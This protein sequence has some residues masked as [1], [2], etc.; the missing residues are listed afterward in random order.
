[1]TQNG[2]SVQGPQKS[3]GSHAQNFTCACLF[4]PPN[5]VLIQAVFAP[6]LD[7]GGGGGSLPAGVPAYC[8]K[9]STEQP[10]Q[11]VEITYVTMS[12]LYRK[13]SMAPHC[14]WDKVQTPRL[15]TQGLGGQSHVDLLPL[16]STP[17][18]FLLSHLHA[19][20]LPRMSFLCKLLVILQ[21][22]APL[23]EIPHIHHLVILSECL[24]EVRTHAFLVSSLHPPPHCLV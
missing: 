1:M 23:K 20:A 7:S 19:F 17:P 14:P 3:E 18:T 24:Q 2:R 13:P 6:L 10:A 5:P 9:S 4:D 16:P 15:G 22:P 8:L 21:S 11:S 12:P